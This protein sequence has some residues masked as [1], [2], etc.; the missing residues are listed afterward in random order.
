[1]AISAETIEKAEILLRE[2]PELNFPGLFEFDPIIIEP[3]RDH[4]GDD[5]LRI[6]VVFD[7]DASRL[8]PGKLNSI[9]ADMALDLYHMGLVGATVEHY[10]EKSEYPEWL[11]LSDPAN[12]MAELMEGM[13]DYELA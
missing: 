6:T 7:G 4:Y 12:W 3:E 11:E 9:G 5:C 10:I 2:Q 1:M 8:D 13:E